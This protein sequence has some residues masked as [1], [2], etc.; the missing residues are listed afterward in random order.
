VLARPWRPGS[1]ETEK[2]TESARQV[3]EE[4][5]GKTKENAADRIAAN[6]NLPVGADETE[7][8]PETTALQGGR[9]KDA[10]FVVVDGDT[11][12]QISIDTNSP[13]SRPKQEKK[14][15]V[16]DARL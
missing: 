3:K 8:T 9:A 11:P 15:A 13:R 2:A 14:A 12:S 10:L 6:E 7:T 4:S 1:F 5:P 16:T